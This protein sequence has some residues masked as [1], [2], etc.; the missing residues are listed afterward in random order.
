MLVGKPEVRL[1]LSLLELA[2]GNHGALLR[3]SVRSDVV[4]NFVQ[5]DYTVLKGNNTA[6]QSF[7]SW[8]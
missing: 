4:R 8:M 2:E 6:N 1:W 7:C 5:E 3:K